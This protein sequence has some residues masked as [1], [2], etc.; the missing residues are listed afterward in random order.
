MNTAAKLFLLC[1]V[2]IA[3]GPAGCARPYGMGSAYREAALERGVGEMN[4]LVSQTVKDPEK[5]KQVQAILKDI[6]AEAQQSFKQSREH[7]QKLFALN[8]SYEATPEQFGKILDDLNNARMASAARILGMRFKIKSLLTA[9]EWK[10]LAQAMD[11]ARSRYAPQP[12]A[13]GM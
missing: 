5:A 8:A 6:V 11:K 12:V 4:E 2:V 1:V 13:G 10:E 7:H 3:M 9:Q